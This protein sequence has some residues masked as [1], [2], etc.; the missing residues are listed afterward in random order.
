M[1][2]RREFVQARTVLVGS[3]VL[4]T[5]C[6]GGGSDSMTTDAGGDGSSLPNLAKSRWIDITDTTFSVT[7]DTYG[8]IDMTLTSI[9]EGTYDPSTEQFSVVLAGPENPT[10]E[11]DKYEVYNSEF[12]YIELYLKPGESSTGVQNYR[13]HFSLLG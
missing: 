12:G 10:F 5:G 8:V 11:E 9:D 7:H 13:T 2:N 3:S 4:L 1:M 6:G